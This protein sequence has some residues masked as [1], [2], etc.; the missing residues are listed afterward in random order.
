MPR[1]QPK[2]RFNFPTRPGLPWLTLILLF[3]LFSPA[4]GWAAG[5]TATNSAAALISEA[6]NHLGLWIWDAKTTD[7]QTCRFWKS[8]TSPPGATVSRA[9]LRIT[10]DSQ[11]Q[12]T[13]KK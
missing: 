2:L 1:L 4:A 10:V 12:A 11:A 5:E 8:F 3:S 9:T 7:K 6:T 13:R